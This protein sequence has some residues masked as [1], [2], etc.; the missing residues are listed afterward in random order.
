MTELAVF[1]ISRP[2]A[3]VDTFTDPER[4]AASL[5]KISVRFEQWDATADLP[6]DADDEAVLDAYANDIARL[7]A[8]GGYQSVDVVRMRPD[9]PDRAALREKFLQEHTHSEDEVR[10]FVEGSGLFFIRHG[11]QV[12]RLRCERGDLLSLPAGVRHWFDGGVEP[13]FAAIRLFTDPKGW[14]AEYTGDDV[15]DRFRTDA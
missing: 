13:H 14:A 4:I 12:H 8:E 1:D 5:A 3:A 7:K 11:D 6:P 10:F 2:R 15:A 9:H